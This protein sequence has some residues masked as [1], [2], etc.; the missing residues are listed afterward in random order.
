MLWTSGIYCICCEFTKLL[1]KV[2][3]EQ[4]DNFFF[5][6]TQVDYIQSLRLTGGHNDPIPDYKRMNFSGTWLSACLMSPASAF[7]PFTVQEEKNKKQKKIR[8]PHSRWSCPLEVSHFSVM[9]QVGSSSLGW[10]LG[11]VQ[12]AALNEPRRSLL[13]HAGV[14]RSSQVLLLFYLLLCARL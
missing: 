7:H 14:L 2:F 11:W 9:E 5:S 10:V 3:L 12:A 4:H 13:C 1:P 8:E 6:S